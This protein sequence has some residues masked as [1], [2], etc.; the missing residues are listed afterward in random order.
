MKWKCHSISAPR[1]FSVC[2]HLFLISALL[3]ATLTQICVALFSLYMIAPFQIRTFS[4]I[5]FLFHYFVVKID[6]W[7]FRYI[8]SESDDCII[9]LRSVCVR[10]W[11]K[12][13]TLD[14]SLVSAQLLQPCEFSLYPHDR[15]RRKKN[16]SMP[17]AEILFLPT[18]SHHC[19]TQTAWRQAALCSP[20]FQFAVETGSTP[21]VYCWQF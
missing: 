11:L 13:P 18:N 12:I 2:H 8:N 19:F 1:R 15:I 9:R 16:L 14:C 4:L 6:D 3:P 20:L 17:N 21:L 10:L 5:V 7:P